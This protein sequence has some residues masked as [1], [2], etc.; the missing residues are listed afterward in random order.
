MKKRLLALA[1]ALLV[2]AALPLSARADVIFTPD[3]DFYEDHYDEMDYV[4]SGYIANGP[5]GALTLYE[6]PEN[7]MVKGTA[8]NGEGVYVSVRYTDDDGVAWAQI[9]LFERALNGW[10]P[11][12]YLV[13]VYN[14]DDFREEFADRVA[15][16]EGSLAASEQPVYF[17]SYPGSD[18]FQADLPLEGDYLPEYWEVF[19]DDAGRKWAHVGYYMG[20]RNAWV[21][22]DAPT[23]DYAALYADHAPQQVTK[24]EITEPTA[25]I[26]PG[27]IS[28]VV[29]IGAAAAVAAVSAA[30]LVVMKKRK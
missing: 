16:E 12:D 23:A 29:A 20:I 15:A 5:G 8:E 4:N 14:S 1:L 18:V 26:K 25:E 19:V 13:K 6:S 30:I 17:W 9:E 21:C 3:D 22:L 24:P 2:M 27:G 7:S 11:M 28:P 10:V